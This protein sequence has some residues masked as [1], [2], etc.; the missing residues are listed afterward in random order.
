MPD[1]P[2][3]HVIAGLAIEDYH[4]R[5]EISKSG[6]DIFHRSPLHFVNRQPM[7][8]PALRLGS[9]VHEAIL[10]PDLFAG[11]WP[12]WRGPSRA[13]KEGKAKWADFQLEHRA[14]LLA[15]RL[16]EVKAGVDPMDQITAM[17]DAV[18]AH[19]LLGPI[20]DDE[21]NAIEHS[22]LWRDAETGVAC[23]CRPDIWSVEDAC[24][25]DLK[26]TED[27]SPRAF[28]R[29]ALTYRYHCQ[30][31]FYRSGAQALLDQDHDHR[32]IFAAVEKSPP[33]A[34]AVYEIDPTST[35]IGEEEI[36]ADLRRYAEC[37]ATGVWPGY[38]EAAQTLELPIRR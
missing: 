8:S 21:E 15:G 33:Y 9:A 29:S 38:P 7:D 36:R 23:R 13:T 14:A 19:P 5:P 31:A 4:E 35:V 37:L 28:A 16:L 34:V 20:L 1:L 25:L 10:E 11:R 24:I 2:L 3:P 30:S 32:F 26:T 18:R 17:A 6:L 27:A 12:V 22:I